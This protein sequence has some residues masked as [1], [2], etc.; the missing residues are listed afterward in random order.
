MRNN[1]S[2]VSESECLGEVDA[3]SSPPHMLDE[4]DSN[5]R[6]KLVERKQKKNGITEL[7]GMEVRSCL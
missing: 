5:S 3:S 2:D 1:R 4:I 6:N 7:I